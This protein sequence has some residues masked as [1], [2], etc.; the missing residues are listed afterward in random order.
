M[1]SSRCPSAS[2]LRS[3]QSL[4]RNSQSC[5]C[6]IIAT[7]SISSRNANGNLP[8]RRTQN[9]RASRPRMR[10]TT[11]RCFCSCHAA[12]QCAAVVGIFAAGMSRKK[13]QK[14]RCNVRRVT[15]NSLARSSSVRL[16]TSHRL[17]ALRHCRCCAAGFFH[18]ED[19]RQVWQYHR[20]FSAEVLP[21]LCI[22]RPHCGQCFFVHFASFYK[23]GYK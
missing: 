7:S 6:A 1:T 3:Y 18:V 9:K 21:L 19:N 8:G 17:N 16:S 2:R 4:N 13:T 5:A 10:L 11:R 14:R 20:C 23:T 22:F 12:K 15:R